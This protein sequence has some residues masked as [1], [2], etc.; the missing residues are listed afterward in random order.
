[1]YTFFIILHKMRMEYKALNVNNYKMYL[2][3]IKLLGLL[4]ETFRNNF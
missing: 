2:V 3:K 4:I 1:M